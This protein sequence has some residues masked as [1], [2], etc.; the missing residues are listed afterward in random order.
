MAGDHDSRGSFIAIARIARTRGIRGEV[1][2][3]IHTD[4]PARFDTLERVWLRLPDGTRESATLEECWEHQ[5]RLVLKLA[6]FDS[7]EASER[8]AGTWVE[9]ASEE[10][11]ALPEGTYFDHDLVGCRVLDLGGGEV[12]TVTEVLRFAGNHQLVVQTPLGECLI[13]A[14]GEI[15]RQVS[16]ERKEIVVELP[17]GL[18]DLNR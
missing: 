5:G 15:C 18:I 11:V 13:P 3:D 1:L 9:V 8:L 12:G 7:I 4:F 2:A 14:R 17:E 16:I 6:G 10:A